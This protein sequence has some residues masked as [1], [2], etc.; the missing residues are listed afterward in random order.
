VNH[1]CRP[2][3]RP[4]VRDLETGKLR[5]AT[6]GELLNHGLVE[7]GAGYYDHALPDG[8]EAPGWCRPVAGGPKRF[9]TIP[10]GLQNKI[11]RPPR[12]RGEQ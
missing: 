9:L 8:D 3:A 1:I 6:D 10:P 2:N 7:T 12:W 4:Q 5:D 11:D